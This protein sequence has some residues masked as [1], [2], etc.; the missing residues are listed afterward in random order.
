MKNFSPGE[1]QILSVTNFQD[2]I[3][4]PFHGEKNVISWARELKGDFYEIV[5]N[6]ELKENIRTVDQEELLKLQLSEQGQLAR[7]ILIHDLSLLK[8]H[9]ASPVLNLIKHYDR[10]PADP[11]FST[12]VYSFHVDRSPIPTNTFLCTYFG[13][14]SEI[15]PNSQAGQKILV[16]EI[17]DELKKQFH[18]TE[19]EFENYLSENFYDLHYQAKPN[20]QP[21][22]LG[23]GHLY[24]LAVDHP[25]SK[26]LPCIHRAPIEKNGQT[27]LLLIC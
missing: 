24:R 22:S 2:L 12:D 5:R 17:R 3:C 21:I 20:A 25:E 23:L 16:P 27:R 26:I 13:E 19:K 6:L 11:F 1:D 10:D 15:I 4:T 18:G 9:G 8:E 7:E 14:T